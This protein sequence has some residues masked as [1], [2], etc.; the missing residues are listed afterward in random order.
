MSDNPNRL[1]PSDTALEGLAEHLLA[2]GGVLSQ[3]VNHMVRSE[4]AGRSSADA[5]AIPVALHELR[6]GILE[7]LAS[8]HPKSEIE[9]TTA[10][11][12]EV[13]ETIRDEVLLVPSL[14]EP[15]RIAP[16]FD[17]P[18]GARPDS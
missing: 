2:C 15:S 6:R 12:A 13:T 18:R 4:A 14:D 8:T 1:D 7:P 3:I 16:G 17:L 11:L 10:M 5:V 9:A